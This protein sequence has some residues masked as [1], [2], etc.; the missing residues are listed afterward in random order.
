VFSEVGR[1]DEGTI[2]LGKFQPLSSEVCERSQFRASDY[3]RVWQ[4]ANPAL[5]DRIV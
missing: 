4:D 5:F 3:L 2:F 1:D